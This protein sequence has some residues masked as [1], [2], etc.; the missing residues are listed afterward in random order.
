MPSTQSGF[1]NRKALWADDPFVYLYCHNIGNE[2]L[3]GNS[4]LLRK[5]QSELK[6]KDFSGKIVFSRAVSFRECSND[7]IGDFDDK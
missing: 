7:R 3:T 6:K 1:Q 5:R 4:V 2:T